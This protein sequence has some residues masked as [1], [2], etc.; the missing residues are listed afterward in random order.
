[1]SITVV[2]ATRGIWQNHFTKLGDF[3]CCVKRESWQ[4]CVCVNPG[5]C[6]YNNCIV[7]CLEDIWPAPIVKL[8]IKKPHLF[9]PDS[10]NG[11][12]EKPSPTQRLSHRRHLSWPLQIHSGVSGVLQGVRDLRPL[13][14]PHS[15]SSHEDRPN[16]GGRPCAIRPAVQTYTGELPYRSSTALT[17]ARKWFI[18]LLW[19]FGQ[20]NTCYLHS[21]KIFFR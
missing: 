4:Y 11:S 20:T 3:Y 16:H 15:A 21:W 18:L 13:L 7:C 10:R 19:I 9:V 6:F 12:L 1:M 8:Y 14:L 5:N 17:N 2:K